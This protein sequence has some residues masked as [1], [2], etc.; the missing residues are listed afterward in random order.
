MSALGIVRRAALSMST[1][2]LGCAPYAA[3]PVS[4]AHGGHPWLAASSP[5]FQIVTD[6]DAD[7]AE[8]I[9]GELEAGLD[10]ISQVAF[11]HARIP[12]E[13]TTVVVFKSESDFHYFRP[14]LV[15]GTFFRKLPGDLEPARFVVLYGALDPGS[16]ISCLH[17]LT[18]DLFE[19]NFGPAPPWLNEGWAQY[20]STIAI[21]PH[22]IRVGAALPHLT[23]TGDSS[24]FTARADDGSDVIAV[25]IDRVAP[26]SSLLSLDQLEFYR[27]TRVEHP[28][29]DDRLRSL[30]LYLGAWAFVHM[31]HDGPEPYPALF[32]QFLERTRNSQVAVAWQATFGNLSMAD[33]D[34]DFRRYLARRE[35]ALFSYGRRTDPPTPIAERA[36]TDADIHVLWARLSPADDAHVLAA[37]Q[38]LDEAVSAA[39]N[40]AEPRYF[41]GLYWL[42][43]HQAALAESDLRAAVDLSPQ[44]PRFLLGLATLR[45]QQEQNVRIQAG[46]AVL[47]AAEPLSKLANSTLQFRALALIYA[48]AGDPERALAFAD[49]SVELSPIDFAALDTRASIL[50]EL[51]RA[52]EAVAVELRAIAFMPE[53]RNVPELSE[54]LRAYQVKARQT[55][56]TEHTP[57]K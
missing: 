37:R 51:G 25:P 35:V 7:E 18:H 17:E 46:D 8:S 54:H 42:Y 38:D 27:S 43:H 14:E 24:F 11:E 39:P 5:H 28:T 36:L 29:R 10:A 32:K 13:P 33:L 6:L 1:A 12:I 44:D 26:P 22:A 30:S 20:Y 50:A 3:H 9:A 16:R 41:R 52:R 48:E 49:R 53:G 45:A 2:L 15:A 4:P 40:A 56:A 31:L 34:R 21:E 57:R 47:Q 19:R 23:F 55:Q